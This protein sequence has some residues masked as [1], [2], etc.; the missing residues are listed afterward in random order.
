LLQSHLL[1]SLFPP[2]GV[3]PPFSKTSWAYSRGSVSRFSALFH[4]S[5]SLFLSLPVPHSLNYSSY[6]ISLKIR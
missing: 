2:V 4:Q 6:K 1:K 3:S 5:L